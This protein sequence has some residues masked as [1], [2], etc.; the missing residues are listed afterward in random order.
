MLIEKLVAEWNRVPVFW[1]KMS[2]RWTAN[3]LTAFCVACMTREWALS[4]TLCFYSNRCHK[5]DSPVMGTAKVKHGDGDVV[6]GVVFQEDKI[7]PRQTITE[8]L[9][10]KGSI[11]RLSNC[12]RKAV[13]GTKLSVTKE[14]DALF[15]NVLPMKSNQKQSYLPNNV[16]VL[17]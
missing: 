10:T 15:F 5:S 17:I 3:C 14:Y 9:Q 12:P 16:Q 2:I 6:S 13:K 8:T 7:Q 1:E 4:S 11:W